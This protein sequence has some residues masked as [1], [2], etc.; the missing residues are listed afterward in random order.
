MRSSGST[1]QSSSGAKASG[2]RTLASGHGVQVGSL[3]VAARAGVIA[4]CV[5][6]LVG[7]RKRPTAFQCRRRRPARADCYGFRRLQNFHPSQPS[8]GPVLLSPARP[9]HR[10][11]P[12]DCPE[13]S[14]VTTKKNASKE[15][16]TPMKRRYVRNAHLQH[17]QDKSCRSEPP[18]INAVMATSN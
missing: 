18:S 14:C 5:F 4:P 7:L 3:L 12:G 9:R 13:F 17:V 16:R 8:L 10:I 6:R 11:K 15:G 1:N 2:C